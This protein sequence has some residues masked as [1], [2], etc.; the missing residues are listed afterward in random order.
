MARQEDL[1]AEAVSLGLL[2]KA[3]EARRLEHLEMIAGG[4]LTDTEIREHIGRAKEDKWLTATVAAR[5]KQLREG[6]DQ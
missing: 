6:D 5:L 1:P 4:R 3:L 2:E